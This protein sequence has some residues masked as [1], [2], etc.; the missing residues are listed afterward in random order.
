MRVGGVQAHPHPHRFQ[1]NERTLGGDGRRDGI[2][3]ALESEK[4]GIA[5]GIDL[6]PLMSVKRFAEDTT[7]LSTQVTVRGTVPSRKLRRAFDVAKQKGHRPTR[8]TSVHT[9]RCYAVTA[10]VIAKA[11]EVDTRGADPR[12]G[13]TPHFLDARRRGCPRAV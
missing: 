9:A 2:A 5:L 3:R 6:V 12:S 7:M 10:P 11:T 8:Q 1:G 4:E 13:R